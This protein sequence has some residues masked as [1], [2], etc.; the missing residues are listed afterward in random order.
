[1]RDNF[2]MKLQNFPKLSHIDANHE[3]RE[4]GD[5]PMPYISRHNRPLS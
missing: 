1:M 3:V 2:G 5:W 4:K